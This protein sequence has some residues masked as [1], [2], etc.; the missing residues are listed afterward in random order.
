VLRADGVLVLRLASVEPK[1]ALARHFGA[2]E[3][4]S[5]DGVQRTPGHTASETPFAICHPFLPYAV[6]SLDLLRPR[7]IADGPEWRSSWLCERPALP[8][9]FLLRG[10]L[11]VIGEIP[12]GIDLRLKFIGPTGERFKLE[13]HVNHISSGTAELL[14]ASQ[15]AEARG[16]LAWAEVE[17]IAL[18]VRTDTQQP[19]D[20]RLADVRIL[21]DAGDT[22]SPRR[23][24]TRTSADLREGYDASYYRS[25]SGYPVYREQRALRELVNVH[26]AYGL[27]PTPAPKRV[28]DIGCGR[29]E[30]AEHLIAQGVEVTLLDYSPTAIEF[31]KSLLGDPPQAH[32]VVDDAA[33]LIAHVAEQSQD[34]I[35]M[36]DFVEHLS[37]AELRTV[38]HACRRALTPTGTLIIHTP[39][40]YSGAITTAKAIHGLHV[41]LFEIDTLSAL[42]EET[43]GAVEVFTWNGFERF[44]RRGYCIELF[45]CAR[46]QE[47]SPPSPLTAR[48]RHEETSADET[49][50]PETLPPETW[51]PQWTFDCPGLPPRFLLDATV[52]LA[53]A[54]AGAS[55]RIDFLT[56]GDTLVAHTE[57]ALSQLET[58]PAHLRL[59]SELLAPQAS[60]RWETVQRIAISA[61]SQ[62]GSAPEIAVSD[63]CLR[64]DHREVLLSG[65]ARGMLWRSPQRS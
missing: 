39:E 15:L 10:T 4:F 54:D 34:A 29:G 51:R 65:E 13:G 59:A 1:Q 45:A 38:L 47:A 19:V 7:V 53:R 21:H 24:A 60:P 48:D 28:L 12:A 14:L 25:M 63:A 57:R 2:V 42:L 64:S 37:V 35:F 41:N 55:L 33:N 44:Q 40:R 9:R 52:D 22:L 5:W 26:R 16:D 8:E 23:P 50:R 17:R 46:P 32:F 3:V 62:A 58:L 49:R 18:E 11:D 61:S 20:V 30:L 43:F 31:A 27:M 6:H 36:T 56:A